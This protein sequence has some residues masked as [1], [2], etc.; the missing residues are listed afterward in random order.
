MF[1]NLADK[2][3]LLRS[4][5]NPGKILI[6]GSGL[7]GSELTSSLSR[8][9]KDQGN[10]EIIEVFKEKSHLCHLLPQQLS[11][12]LFKIL[13]SKTTKLIPESEVISISEINEGPDCGRLAVSIKQINKESDS[14]NI[15]NVDHVVI[16]VINFF[17]SSLILK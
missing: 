17:N 9:A 13:E 6:I 1:R 14:N 12:Y 16:A 4:K 15:E 8:V 2:I 7:L 10:L 3:K 5:E 11:N